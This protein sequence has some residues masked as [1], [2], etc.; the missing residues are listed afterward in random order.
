MRLVRGHW[1]ATAEIV[2]LLRRHRDLTLE[3]AKRELSDRYAG[4]AF[5]LLW[6]VGHPMFMIGLYVFI[7]AIVFRQKIGGTREMP[8]DYTAY[9]LSGL[10][11]WMSVQESMLKSCTVITGNAALVKQVVFPLEILPVKS[12]LAS[13]FP[14]LVSLVLLMAYVLVTH[15]SLHATYA[16]LPVLVTMQLM[17]MIGIAY[18]LSPLGVYFRDAKD[19]VQLFAMAGAYLVPVFY[20][21]N[22]VP[23]PFKPVLYLNPFSY[24][25]WCYQ[26]ALYFGRFEHPWAWLAVSVM[27]TT[28]FALG[29]RVFRKLKPTLGNML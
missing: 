21:P 14:Q 23:A 13:L 18:V 22:W 25:I 6:A 11:A 2:S 27:S 3:M 28:T 9:L 16:L 5:G 10:V 12:V 17:W 20:L 29:Y 4:Q 24:L 1:Q 15:G 8:L 19:F 7:F 26:D